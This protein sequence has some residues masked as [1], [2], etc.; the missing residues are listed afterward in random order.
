[1]ASQRIELDLDDGVL[2]NHKKLQ[3]ETKILTPIK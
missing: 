2:V 1:V 3:A